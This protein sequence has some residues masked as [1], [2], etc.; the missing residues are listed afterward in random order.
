[1]SGAGKRC[2]LDKMSKGLCTGHEEIPDPI[3]GII[4]IRN[5]LHTVLCT[6]RVLQSCSCVLQFHNVSTLW[7]KYLRIQKYPFDVGTDIISTC[8]NDVISFK[9]E[10][11]IYIYTFPRRKKTLLFVKPIVY[12]I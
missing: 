1:M 9:R 5:Q 4:S 11:K 3:N 10:K 2:E 8:T 6:K 7:M 12:P